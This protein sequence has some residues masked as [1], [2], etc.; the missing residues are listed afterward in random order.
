MSLFGP[1]PEQ[2][3]GSTYD[4]YETENDG[5][6]DDDYDKNFVKSQRHRF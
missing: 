4:H 2:E 5:D 3:L 6:D 1:Y